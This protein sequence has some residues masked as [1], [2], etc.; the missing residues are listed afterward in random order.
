MISYFGYIGYT[1]SFSCVAKTFLFF[2]RWPCWV[3]LPCTAS[4]ASSVGN[5][6]KSRVQL[7]ELIMESKSYKSHT[8]PIYM[9]VTLIYVYY[10]WNNV[11]SLS[12]HLL[13]S[14]MLFT[15]FWF[16]TMVINSILC[17]SRAGS[18]YITW[19]PRRSIHVTKKGASQHMKLLNRARSEG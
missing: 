11:Y 4:F 5:I 19:R 6:R 3:K 9:Y 18:F 15:Y 16:E 17:R 13:F 14:N 12:R 10:G 8:F 2:T 1:L 7:G